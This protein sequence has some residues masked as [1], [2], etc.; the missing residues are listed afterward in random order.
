MK[1]PKQ[2]ELKLK[3]FIKAWSDLAAAKTIGGLSLDQAKDALKPS[4]DI[5]DEIAEG[6][7]LQLSRINAREGADKTSLKLVTR[8]INAI[9][10]DPE[11]GEDSDLYEAVGYIRASERRHGKRRSKIVELQKAA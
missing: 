1:A 10:A 4:F 9:K 3:N 2:T 7:N 6:E 8:L 11:L 5:R